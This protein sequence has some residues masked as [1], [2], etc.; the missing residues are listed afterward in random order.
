[1][2]LEIW[3]KASVCYCLLWT[4][5]FIIIHS[6]NNILVDGIDFAYTIKILITSEKNSLGYS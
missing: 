1:M 2:G 3:L 5:Y 4:T 6:Q